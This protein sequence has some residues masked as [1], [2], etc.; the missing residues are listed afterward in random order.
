MAQRMSEPDARARYGRRI[1]TIEPVFGTIE[2]TMAFTRACSR[3]TET[4]KAEV[5]LK[6]LTY[7][8]MRLHMAASTDAPRRPVYIRGFQNSGDVAEASDIGRGLRRG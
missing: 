7:N 2:D 8:L 5:M 4:V 1:A 3:R 6:L